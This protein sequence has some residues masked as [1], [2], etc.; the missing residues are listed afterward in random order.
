VYNFKKKLNE[1]PLKWLRLR[2]A[3]V[4]NFICTDKRLYGRENPEK[5][6]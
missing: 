6:W 1:K 2:Q 4:Q 3:F 5:L